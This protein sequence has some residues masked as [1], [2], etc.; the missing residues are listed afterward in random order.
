LAKTASIYTRVEPE[1]KIKAEQILSD[2]G[3]PVSNAVNLFL[4]QII[5]HKGLPFDVK[6]PKSKPLD[7]SMLTPEQFDLE[8]E[9][10]FT[11][12]AEGRTFSSLEVRD[13]MQR[14]YAK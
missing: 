10:G 12:I 4:H 7:Y 1:L 3:I 13:R 2:L 5:M 6:L 9:K 8:I 11:S 14:Q